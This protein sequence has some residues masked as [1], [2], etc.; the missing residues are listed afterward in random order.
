MSQLITAIYE[1]GVLRPTDP[2]TLAEAQVVQLKVM[3][4]LTPTQ[5]YLQQLRDLGLVTPP[6]AQP[7]EE[8]LPDIDREQLANKFGELTTKPISE[9]IIE[10]R[11]L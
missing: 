7:D 10:E 5:Q 6:S 8:R 9:I 4:Q 2:L 1:N 11:G 3:P